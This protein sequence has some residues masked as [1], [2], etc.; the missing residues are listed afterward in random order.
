VP[1]GEK[2]PPLFSRGVGEYNELLDGQCSSM[3]GVGEY[4]ELL[5]GQCSSM[6]GV[7]EYNELLDGGGG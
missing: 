1:P 5:D 2:C 4:N 7:G 3:E 6:E